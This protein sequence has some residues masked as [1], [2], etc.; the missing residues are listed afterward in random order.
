MN[1]KRSPFRPAMPT[2]CA[3]LLL[4]CG[5]GSGPSNSPAS[6]VEDKPNTP[7]KKGQRK[8][9]FLIFVA[10]SYSSESMRWPDTVFQGFVDGLAERGWEQDQDYRVIRDTM[11]SV[12]KKSEA[13]KLQQGKRMLERIENEKPDLV[14]T[15]DDDALRYVGLEI[16]NR[17]VVFNGVNGS[18]G[19]YRDSSPLIDSL[20][21]PGHN[22]T[23]VFQTTYFKQS[24]QLISR[25]NP[26][27]KTFAVIVDGDVTGQFLLRELK[28]VEP[29]LPL[30]W[31]ETF[32]SLNF[33]E[34][35]PKIRD[36]EERFD[37]LYVLCSGSAQDGTGK[38]LGHHPTLKWIA[39]NTKLPTTGNWDFQVEDGLL[40][41]AADTGQEQGRFSAY[42]ASEILNGA[43]PG[44]LPIMTPPNGIP[45]LNVK[46]AKKLGLTVPQEMMNMF[47][48][49]G[50][51][52]R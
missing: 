32:I 46:T 11:D 52:Y 16:K 1:R 19:K 39:A 22:I 20:E 27:A 30:E 42:L 10:D 31:K 13:E 35:K 47:V 5:N 14:V 15:T 21:K 2:L 51:I 50:R 12:V 28:A 25:L 33:E 4:G 44:D 40:V 48:D 36:W 7:D 29:P 41:S 24:L 3:V 6:S 9:P 49:D 18:P 45:V 43:N 23:G 37:A 17:P 26:K 8:E 34:W 38:L